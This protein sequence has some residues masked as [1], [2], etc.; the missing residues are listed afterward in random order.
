MGNQ[1]NEIPDGFKK[2]EI[3][4]IPEDW[5]VVKLGE[6]AEVVMGQS[7]PGR[8]YNTVGEG[9]PFLQGKAEFGN[10]FPHHIKYTTKPLKIASKGSILISV[11]A[12]VGDVNV[13]DRDY[14]IG[15]GLASLN[16]KNGD[17]LFLFN[18]LKYLKPRLEREGTGSTFKAINKTKLE[19]FLISLPPLPEQKK[20][21]HV[22]STIQ[23]AKEKTE[24][25]IKAAK[26]LKKSLMKYLFTYGPVPL[27]EAENVKLKETEVGLI[28]EDWGVV[29]LVDIGEFQYGYTE[30]A[31]FKPIGPK[32]LRI[33][34]ISDEGN[35]NWN[36]APYC[37]IDD[38]AFKKYE[39]HDG[40]ILIA[41][42]GATTGK[43]CIVKNPPPSVFASYLI[44]F[45][46]KKDNVN[47]FFIY[48]FM[49]SNLY[50]Q[51]INAIKEGKLKKGVSASLLKNLLIPLPPLHIQQKIASILSA[52]DEKIE[53]EEN[54]KKALEELFKSM[55]HNLMTGKV[56]VK[57]L[58]IE[59]EMG[60][61]GE[62][63]LEVD[64]NVGK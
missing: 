28:P 36:T 52:V 56:R 10:I 51:Q 41:R 4:I 6:V 48:Y 14:C 37:N 32:F 9:M 34:D 43:T 17:N 55:L 16:L 8:T 58:D 38:D 20:I 31:T 3:G 50:W 18:L 24:A 11:R 26:E 53:K 47:P 59:I 61:D 25:V 42:I 57:D 39:L 29:K 35:I 12:P 44:R 15:R 33:T 54:K 40:D 13:A 7:P 22:L 46:S 19:N 21:A 1:N 63:K 23:E 62:T 49:R 5:E 2:T 30:T 27:N 60:K 45:S 64:E